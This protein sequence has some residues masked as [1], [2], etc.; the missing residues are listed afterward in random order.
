M[1]IRSKYYFVGHTVDVADL[2]GVCI[3]ELARYQN[4]E[5]EQ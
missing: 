2:M 4:E 5:R 3:K 1:K